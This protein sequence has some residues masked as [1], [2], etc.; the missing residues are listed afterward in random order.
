[1]VPIRRRTE[2]EVPSSSNRNSNGEKI[3]I[4]PRILETSCTLQNSCESSKIRFQVPVKGRDPKNAPAAPR[5]I[6]RSSG[7]LLEDRSPG[8]IEHAKS[9]KMGTLVSGT[10]T[11]RKWSPTGLGHARIKP[12]GS[13]T[14]S[15]QTGK[16]QRHHSNADERGLDDQDRRERRVQPPRSEREQRDDSDKYEE[17]RSASTKHA[18]FR[19]KL[20]S[21]LVDNANPWSTEESKK[22]GSDNDRLSRRHSTH[23]QIQ[24][25]SR[26]CTSV[27]SSAA[28]GSRYICTSHKKSSGTNSSDRLSRVSVEH[29][30]LL[31][32][33]HTTEICEDSVI[34]E[35]NEV[36]EVI[37]QERCTSITRSVSG[38]RTR[39]KVSHHIEQTITTSATNNSQSAIASSYPKN[40]R[41]STSPERLEYVPAESSRSPSITE[42]DPPGSGDRCIRHGVRRNRDAF[43]GSSERDVSGDVRILETKRTRSADRSERTVNGNCGNEDIHQLVQ[44][45]QC[46]RTSESGQHSGIVICKSPE[47]RQE[48][49]TAHTHKEP[50]KTADQEKPDNHSLVDSIRGQHTTRRTEQEDTGQDR[51]QTEPKDIPSSVQNV[52]S[53]TNNRHV[54]NAGEQTVSKVCEFSTKFRSSV[55]ECTHNAITTASKGSVLDE[56]PLEADSKTDEDDTGATAIQKVLLTGPTWNSADAVMDR[57]AV[58]PPPASHGKKEVDPDGPTFALRELLGPEYAE[59]GMGRCVLAILERH[60]KEHAPEVEEL[61]RKEMLKSFRHATN[62]YA[63]GHFARACKRLELDFWK[64][65]DDN[66]VYAVVMEME[67]LID[68]GVSKT[69]VANIIKTWR[70]CA[71]SFT[72]WERALYNKN[73]GLKRL[74]DYY[75][76]VALRA[77]GGDAF[78]FALFFRHWREYCSETLLGLEKKGFF[79]PGAAYN[80]R[81]LASLRA[82]AH[83]A[84]RLVLIGRNIDIWEIRTYQYQEPTP[85]R[86]PLGALWLFMRRKAS[87]RWKWEPVVPTAQPEPFC[88]VRLFRLYLWKLQSSPA[89]K[90]AE[91]MDEWGQP[92]TVWRSSL[93]TP[94]PGY[95]KPHHPLAV[96]TLASE[97]KRILHKCGV[98]NTFTAKATRKSVA[99]YL[100]EVGEPVDVVQSRGNW[101]SMLVFQ[102]HYSRVANSK[103]FGDIL[104][105]AKEKNN[106]VTSSDEVVEEMNNAVEVFVTKPRDRED[107]KDYALSVSGTNDE[108]VTRTYIHTYICIYV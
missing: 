7:G 20:G 55:G 69:T 56:P 95:P 32:H 47:I 66:D 37:M 28:R 54:C 63:V 11:R 74:V 70:I 36:K 31:S 25:R 103:M 77:T 51:L 96:T 107:I 16:F 80:N 68:L 15:F 65:I 100:L 91:K 8:T 4:T 33:T 64:V 62:G 26:S 88:A 38:S 13:D 108:E 2:E 23:Q 81:Y 24:S 58:V 98:P 82:L 41:H 19:V 72:L 40:Q 57:R 53:E 48:G 92:A 50:Q 22:H 89:W 84:L 76:Q 9:D 17:I 49:D 21:V 39:G 27:T 10:K 3:I 97:C 90:Q 59:A 101:T 12:D 18:G 71:A 94:V 102:Q 86:Y 83:V 79:R 87:K 52:E 34:G 29:Q 73:C 45:A 60:I 75:C 46:E 14:T 35:E 43:E 5:P 61:S 30:E 1:M 99:T 104:S 42:R 78:D 93:E 85:P 105:K 67:K 44:S 106:R 6:R